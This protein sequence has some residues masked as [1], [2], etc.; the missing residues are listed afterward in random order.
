[1]KKAYLSL[2]FVCL[3]PAVGLSFVVGDMAKIGPA[4]MNLGFPAMPLVAS[5]GE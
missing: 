1:M 3:I 5:Y 4:P 2:I